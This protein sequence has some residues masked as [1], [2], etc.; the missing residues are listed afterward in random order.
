MMYPIYKKA[1]EIFV[2]DIEL[3]FYR[4]GIE[5]EYTEYKGKTLIKILNVF[6]SEVEG[7]G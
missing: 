2:V 7:D 5:Y 4:L 3:G 6:L 1:L